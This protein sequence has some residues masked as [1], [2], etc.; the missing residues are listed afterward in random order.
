MRQDPESGYGI[1]VAFEGTDFVGVIEALQDCFGQ[2]RHEAYDVQSKEV[3][4]S[5]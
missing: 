2:W 4:S 3:A 1:Y 5:P